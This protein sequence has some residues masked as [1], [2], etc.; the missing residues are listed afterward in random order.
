VPVVSAGV[1]EHEQ[2]F[3]TDDEMMLLLLL[4]A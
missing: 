4:A 3:P 2:P 1:G